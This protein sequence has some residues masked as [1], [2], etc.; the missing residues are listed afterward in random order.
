ML[1][2][3]LDEKIIGFLKKD[4]RTPFLKIAKETGVSESTV[5]KRVAKLK[6]NGVIRAFTLL[7]DSSLAFE[8][9]VAVKCMPKQ[10]KKVSEQIKKLSPFLP[11]V[12]V[13]GRYDIFCTVFAPT[14]R[15][16][17]DL[18]DKIR[19]INGVVETE[20]FFVVEKK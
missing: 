10:T 15:G 7:L 4:C 5:R 2:D 19:G 1:L 17:N 9:I 13:T 12:E 18:I 20:S 8:S 6:S 11:V 14:T 3:P 16:L